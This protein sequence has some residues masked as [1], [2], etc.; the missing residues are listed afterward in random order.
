MKPAK[1]PD[2]EL[3]RLAALEDYRILDTDP[4]QAFDDLTELAAYI[5]DV[6]IALVSLIDAERQWFKSRV[7]LDAQQTP[8][9][10]AFCTHAILGRDL[11][12]V[13][14][15]LRDDRFADNPLVTGDPAIR[16]Y[17]G[18]PLVEPGGQAMGTLCVIDRQPRQLTPEQESALHALARQT[19]SQM[20]LRKKLLEQQSLNEQLRAAEAQAV[21]ANR[22]KSRFLAH[23]SHE[24]RTP[25]NAIIGFSKVLRKTLVRSEDPTPLTYLQRVTANGL[26]LL[27]LVNNL[28]DISRIEANQLDVRCEPFNLDA[29]IEETASQVEPLVL[30]QGNTLEVHGIG[31]TVTMTSDRTR[32]RQCLL[33]L[34]SNACKFTEKGV[35]TLSAETETRD[36]TPWVRFTVR[37]TGCGMSPDQLARAFNEFYRAPEGGAAEGTGLGLAITHKFCDLLGGT[38]T[39]RSE[40]GVGSSFVIDL[41][42]AGPTL[43]A[44]PETGSAESA[45][46]TAVTAG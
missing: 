17:A 19:V 37:D 32:I 12:V 3:L 22:T 27:E 6:P 31:A 9:D 13:N 16:F 14:D 15:A 10:L 24:F 39:A 38:V 25:L 11:F 33:N 41:P 42:L 44:S 36:D 46:Q 4:E 23:M 1:L 26:H 34:L 7:G 40:P 43:A 45:S 21:R 5:C 18:S 30:Q 2:N 20:E 35:I 8:R 29:L 28:L